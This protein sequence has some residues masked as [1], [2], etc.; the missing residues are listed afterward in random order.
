MAIMTGKR[1]KKRPRVIS[2]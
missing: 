2:W 1:N